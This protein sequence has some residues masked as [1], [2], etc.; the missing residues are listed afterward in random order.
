M[1]LLLGDLPAFITLTK[2]LYLLEQ[3]NSQLALPLGLLIMPI[4]ILG[5]ES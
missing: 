4:V 3:I 1:L 2:C 5:I